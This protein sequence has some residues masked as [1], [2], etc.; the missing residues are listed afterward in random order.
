MMDRAWRF[1]EMAVRHAFQVLRIV[2]LRASLASLTLVGLFVGTPPSHARTWYVEPDSTGDAPTIQAA[3]DSAQS[4]DEVLLAPGTYTRSSQG[5]DGVL[6][7]PSMVR[8]KPAVNLRGEAGPYA[9]I[10][11]GEG[12]VRVILCQD[13][14]EVRIE[15]LTLAR[16]Y[17]RQL[18][19]GAGIG[20]RG[21]SRPLIVN[22]IIRDGRTDPET[23]G[24]AI[25]CAAATITN[26]Q[27]LDN[28]C[29]FDGRGGGISCG[30]GTVISG[31]TIRNNR[32]RGDPGGFGG[33]VNATG[34]AI[35]DC[36]IENNWCT[37]PFAS[38]GGGVYGS[39]TIER[40]TFVNNLAKC[41]I[42]GDARGGAVALSG[43][44]TRDCVFVG[45][46]ARGSGVPGR[47]GAIAG[48]SAPITVTGCTLI[49]NS[50]GISLPGGGQVSST[51]VAW[52]Q[53]VACDGTAIFT[54]NNSYGNAL[55]DA[56]CG[57]GGGGNFSVDPQFCATDPATSLN[58]T[59]QQDSPC[60][61]GNHPQGASCGRIGAAPV[62]C[63]AVSIEQ[64]P[65]T[66]VKLLY[67]RQGNG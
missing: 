58:F 32:T 37:G 21:D 46:I 5:D 44:S 1:A 41:Q 22:C 53:L 11:D 62:G 28:A 50:S 16:G 49:G 35:R 45:N 13:V 40:C 48:V 56:I 38:A 10:L 24:A 29:G 52:T 34:A 57:R 8:M 36:W 14:G 54:C 43:G 67:R 25:S 60:A 20:S 30:P 63:G 26:C 7:D 19:G 42:Q 64:I 61:P 6:F 18:R 23:N 39:A 2:T 3:I 4:G 31:C 17:A 33:G 47:G 27:I 15:G 55:G 51:I 59:L 65:W 12:V 66:K 9:T